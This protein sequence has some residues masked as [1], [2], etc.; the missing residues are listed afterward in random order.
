MLK[1][2]VGTA[3]AD[4]SPTIAVENLISTTG[5]V[6]DTGCCCFSLS[7]L[8]KNVFPQRLCQTWMEVIGAV[9]GEQ[10][11]ALG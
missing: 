3:V 11:Q 9:C 4:K 6:E 2:V 10:Q 1:A 5:A 8:E 7:K